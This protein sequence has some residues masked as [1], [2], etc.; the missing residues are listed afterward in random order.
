MGK[1]AKNRAGANAAHGVIPT[2]TE[3]IL[4]TEDAAKLLGVG[5]QALRSYNVPRYIVGRNCL[6]FKSDLFQW[7]RMCEQRGDVN[8]DIEW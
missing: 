5:V 3:E 7:V 1:I 6:Y 2:I 8:L 4:K